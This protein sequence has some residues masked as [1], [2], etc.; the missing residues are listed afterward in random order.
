[1]SL[2]VFMVTPTTLLMLAGFWLTGAAIIASL[3]LLNRRRLQHAD[4]PQE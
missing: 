4:D 1:M 3:F 2:T